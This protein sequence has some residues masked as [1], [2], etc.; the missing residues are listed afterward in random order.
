M[1]VWQSCV[2]GFNHHPFLTGVFDD[3]EDTNWLRID[4]SVMQYIRFSIAHSFA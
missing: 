1:T 3:S 2:S 4:K